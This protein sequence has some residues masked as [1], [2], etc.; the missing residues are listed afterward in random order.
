[1]QLSEQWARDI[2]GGEGIH[3][4]AEVLDT[5]LADPVIFL[6]RAEERYWWDLGQLLDRIS[7]MSLSFASS[8]S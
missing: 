2:E 6:T 3:T 1:M 7:N 5:V 4:V 8:Q